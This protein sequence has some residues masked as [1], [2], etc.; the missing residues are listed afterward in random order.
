MKI[1]FLDYDS[2][3]A[4][5][6]PI[7]ILVQVNKSLPKQEL[8]KLELS[9]PGVSRTGGNWKRIIE[10]AKAICKVIKEGNKS[11]FEKENYDFEYELITGNY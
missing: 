7:A 1:L 9:Q 4:Y 8:K 6:D 11:D 3:F 5:N 10:D 2:G